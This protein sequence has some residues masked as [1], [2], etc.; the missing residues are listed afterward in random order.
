V[1]N[2]KQHA[3]EVQ[4]RRRESGKVG[5]AKAVRRFVWREYGKGKET[6]YL[7]ALS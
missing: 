2:T 7:R 6:S 5:Y 3:R 4:A 1:I